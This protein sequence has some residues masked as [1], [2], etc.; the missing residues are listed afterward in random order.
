MLEIK[1]ILHA[2]VNSLCGLSSCHL[3]WH[4][5][6]VCLLHGHVA[7]FKPFGQGVEILDLLLSGNTSLAFAIQSSM[8]E[9]A[10]PQ[11]IKILASDQ[12]H[13]I[14]LVHRETFLTVHVQ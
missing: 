1:C 11:D 10:F 4:L 14:C 2:V 6:S 13:G 8:I 5:H 12:I 9:K 3:V 7:H